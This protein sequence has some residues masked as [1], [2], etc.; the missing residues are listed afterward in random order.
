VRGFVK[1]FFEKICWNLAG[2][3]D[4]VSLFPVGYNKQMS[5]RIGLQ[6]F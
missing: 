2:R 6:E 3:K 4:I 5:K 1:G